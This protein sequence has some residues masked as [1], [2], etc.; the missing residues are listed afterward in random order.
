MKLNCIGVD[1]GHRLRSD[2]GAVV[3]RREDDLN[4]LVGKALNSRFKTIGINSGSR[5]HYLED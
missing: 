2:V 4:L 1:I 5:M 3:I